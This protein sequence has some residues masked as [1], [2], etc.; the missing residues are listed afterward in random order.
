M[1]VDRFTISSGRLW[2]GDPEF[3]WAECRDGEGCILAV[4]NGTYAVEAKG[5]EFG[6]PRL[7]TRMRV[8]LDGSPDLKTGKVVGEVGTD[9]GQIGV[10]DPALFLEAITARIKDDEGQFL[11]A[12]ESAFATECGVY[13]PKAKVLGCIVYVPAG[14]GDGGG[15]VWSLRAGRRM[16]GVETEFIP[17]NG[18]GR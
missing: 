14:L 13:R 4:P 18:S 15:P 16:V 17:N 1:L 7:A 2:I 11:D 8:Y 5:R 10:G 6:G 9:S 12:L 3:S